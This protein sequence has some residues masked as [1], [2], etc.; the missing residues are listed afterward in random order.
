MDLILKTKLSEF[1]PLRVHGQN[2]HQLSPQLLALLKR[3]NVD[4]ADIELATPKIS[5]TRGEIQ[6]FSHSR[7]EYKP[8]AS[9]DEAK[10]Q[11]VNIQV[12]Q[13]IEAVLALAGRLEAETGNTEHNEVQLLRGSVSGIGVDHTYFAE[14]ATGADKAVLL[15]CWG[16]SESVEQEKFH[17]MS[18]SGKPSLVLTD[19]TE[20]KK[21]AR[22]EAPVP[23]AEPDLLQ[24]DVTAPE[25][26]S[27]RNERAPQPERRTW[28][29]RRLV[30]FLL[31]LL[32]LL[33]LLL[34]MRGCG[35]IGLPP[36]LGGGFGLPS[37]G[38][39]SIGMPLTGGD[40]AETEQSLRT[41]IAALKARLANDLQACTIEEPQAGLV[42]PVE[43]IPVAE[44]QTEPSAEERLTREGSF[45]G[46]VNVSLVW[47]NRHDLDLVVEDPN[48]ELIYF[49]NKQS[50]SGGYLDVDMNAGRAQTATPIE[51]IKWN[52]LDAAPRG[53]YKVYVVYFSSYAIDADIDPTDFTVTTTIDGEST[54]T[55]GRVSKDRLKKRI[56]VTSFELE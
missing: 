20:L 40:A 8:F 10:R 2:L 17:E 46:A 38:A 37:V 54:V 34:L 9:L 50:I 52:D 26:M 39:P 47:N 14:T 4:M 21:D 33:L 16:C 19:D 5:H 51:N 22:H 56:F 44:P 48:G 30:P 13:F 29:W 23:D 27:S 11:A 31:M 36:M 45:V 28:N 43:D 12:A 7:L 6:W 24:P 42:S 35:A 41:E 3:N 49:Q 18:A 15:C 53:V 55:E 25:V 32:L 1:A